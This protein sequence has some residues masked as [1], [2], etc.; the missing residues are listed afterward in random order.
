MHGVCA[1]TF[2]RHGSLRVALR[3][4]LTPPAAKTTLVQHGLRGARRRSK[5]VC[6]ALWG[7]RMPG[8]VFCSL[9]MKDMGRLIMTAQRRVIFCGPG[10]NQ[11]VASAICQVAKRLGDASVQAIL[12]VN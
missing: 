5:L 9:T 10:L 6:E 2:H 8:S 7:K 4:A 1:A 12:D 11:D 3:F